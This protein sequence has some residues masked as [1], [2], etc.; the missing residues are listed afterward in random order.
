MY[1]YYTIQRWEL[2]KLRSTGKK[3]LNDNN[4]Q[5]HTAKTVNKG[6]PRDRQNMVFIDKWSLFGG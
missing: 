3:G 6:H 4:Q 2:L 1:N 5:Q